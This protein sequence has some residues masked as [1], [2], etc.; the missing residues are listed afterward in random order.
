MSLRASIRLIIRGVIMVQ[1]LRGGGALRCRRR[2]EIEASKA[3]SWEDLKRVKI[4]SPLG[5][6]REG[7]VSSPS[8]RTPAANEI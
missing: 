2:L 5:N 4:P 1:N 3:P 7:V 8:P 6:M